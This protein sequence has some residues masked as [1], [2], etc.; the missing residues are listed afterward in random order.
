MSKVLTES[1]HPILFVGRSF[2][3][4]IFA[5][6]KRIRM[7]RSRTDRRRLSSAEAKRAT[8]RNIRKSKKS[9]ISVEALPESSEAS[10]LRVVAAPILNV[11]RDSKSSSMTG[12]ATAQDE[13]F[14]LFFKAPQPAMR[15][16]IIRVFEDRMVRVTILRRDGFVASSAPA[17]TARLVAL[18]AVFASAA[19]FSPI[20]IC[21]YNNHGLSTNVFLATGLANPLE[22]GLTS[23][24]S[25]GLSIKS[26]SK[27]HTLPIAAAAAAAA[28][29]IMAV[30]NVLL[31]KT[32]SRGTSSCV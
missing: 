15:P 21:R 9:Q 4:K 14:P 10:D 11:D 28:T 19:A 3:Y 5:C 7:A 31:I 18:S 8:I 2:N 25:C 16:A 29:T 20:S 30:E 27:E 32:K 1:L 17:V 12:S 22:K 13:I 24:L 26:F 6:D 23:T